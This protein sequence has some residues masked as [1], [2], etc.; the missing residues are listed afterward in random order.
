MKDYFLNE[1]VETDRV[2]LRQRLADGAERWWPLV[3][4]WDRLRCEGMPNYTTTKGVPQS[5]H[6]APTLGHV[7]NHGTHHVGQISAAI[8]ARGHACPE[9]DLIWM[10]QAQATR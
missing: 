8:T 6:F 1:E 7:F 5:P 10:L 2:R 9:L 4:S 3:A